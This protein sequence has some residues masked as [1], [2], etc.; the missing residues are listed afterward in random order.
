MNCTFID[1]N[2]FWYEKNGTIGYRGWFQSDEGKFFTAPTV[3][4]LLVKAAG[5]MDWKG[6]EWR[7]IPGEGPIKKI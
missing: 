6:G 1:G 3:K 2:I 4:S 7:G 5:W